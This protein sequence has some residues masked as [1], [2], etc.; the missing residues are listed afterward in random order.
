MSLGN[1]AQVECRVNRG[2][3]EGRVKPRAGAAVQLHWEVGA[4]VG[5][6]RGGVRRSLVL[7]KSLAKERDDSVPGAPPPRL[8]TQSLTG[9]ASPEAIPQN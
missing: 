2:D 6:W 5:G 8:T 3:I 1:A 9:H 7:E 4:E